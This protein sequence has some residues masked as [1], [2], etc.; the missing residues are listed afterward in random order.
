M[1]IGKQTYVLKNTP[2]IQECACIVGPKEGNG[3]MQ[4]YFDKI[5]QDVILDEASFEKAESKFVSETISTLLSKSNLKPEDIDI[6][7]GGDLLNQCIA[8]NYAL[9]KLSIPFLGLYGACSTYVEGLIVNSL[10][11]NAGYAQKMINVSSSHYCSAERQ[12]RLPLEQGGQ[13]APTSQWT[14]TGSGA[15]LI[16]QKAEPPYITHVTIGKV[17]DYGITDV[18]NMGAAMA[19]AA[20]DTILTHL[21]D[22]GRDVNYY[23]LIITGDLGVLGSEILVDLCKNN[24]VDLSSI[25]NDCGK[26]IFHEEDN[27][28]KSGASGCACCATIFSGYFFKELKNKNINKI[29]L[30]ATG[31]LMSPVSTLQGESIPSIAHAI[32]IENNIGE[33]IWKY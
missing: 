24:D 9:R 27:D 23:D 11:V 19:P 16:T 21:Y 30:V 18:T 7:S 26:L 31:A 13:K 8:S 10:L 4:K 5:M 33:D 28:V 2:T 3:P 29:L 20:V 32:S 14:V 12:F 6:A 15:A 17:I 22:T 1:K 25:H